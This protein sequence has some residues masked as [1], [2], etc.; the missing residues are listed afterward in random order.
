TDDRP[1]NAEVAAHARADG[2]LVNAVDDVPNCDF[3]ATSIVQRGEAQIAIS[4]GGG[5]PAMARW[6]R[7]QLDAAIPAEVGD[8]L[9]AL[10]DVRARLKAEHAIPP[11]ASWRAA[12]E[13]ALRVPQTKLA[14]GTVYL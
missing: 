2:R 8:L 14:P 5:S 10:A 6:L 7:E 12:I 1:V 3:I 11:Y 4:T 13:A 9:D